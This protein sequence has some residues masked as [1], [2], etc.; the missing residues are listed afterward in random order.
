MT[1]EPTQPQSAAA[2]PGFD[3][4]LARLEKIVAEL[5]RGEVGLETAIERY[6]E[7]VEIVRRCRALLDGFQKRVEEL[8]ESGN[9]PY[10]ADPDAKR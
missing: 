8:T 5:E 10:A 1:K 2:E 4:R 6:Q 9:V 3:E 7:G